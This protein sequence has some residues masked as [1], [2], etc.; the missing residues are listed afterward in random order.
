MKSLIT[1]AALVLFASAAYAQNIIING[2]TPR[3][4]AAEYGSEKIEN[5]PVKQHPFDL[6]R[7]NESPIRG[8]GQIKVVHNEPIPGDPE[9]DLHKARWLLQDAGYQCSIPNQ[10]MSRR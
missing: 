5:V 10:R 1:A 7:L 6:G 3:E 4:P 2:A 9:A 8:R